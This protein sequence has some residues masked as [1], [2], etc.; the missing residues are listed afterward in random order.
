MLLAIVAEMGALERL[1]D[2]VVAYRE[3]SPAPL[4][5]QA[6]GELQC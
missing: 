1:F 3:L 2:I 4:A 5:S 6:Y